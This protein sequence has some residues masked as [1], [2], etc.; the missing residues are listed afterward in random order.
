MSP[1]ARYL[2]LFDL[3]KYREIQPIVEGI[4]KRDVDSD[5]VNS[6]VKRVLSIVGSD[7]YKKYNSPDRFY[8]YDV[9][10][11][12]MVEAVREG[13][14]LPWLDSMKHS[15][16]DLTQQIILAICCPRY[17]YSTYNVEILSGTTFEY[18]DGRYCVY[19]GLNNEALVELLSFP[20]AM[21]MLPNE[22]RETYRGIFDRQ[23]L[24]ELTDLVEEALLELS[25]SVHTPT[26][27]PHYLEFV[28]F[29]T[30]FSKLLKLANS[31]PN[32]TILNER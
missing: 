17:Q 9:E 7:N 14:L 29:Y 21:E 10:F 26:E 6:L 30:D 31:Q 19:Y 8:Y 27:R 11:Q 15:G 18:A 13:H 25:R 1:S 12:E 3:E 20:D 22:D 5:R 2:R 23:Q 4:T 32:Y 28:K 16:T 24:A